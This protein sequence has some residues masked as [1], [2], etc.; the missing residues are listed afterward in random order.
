VRLP[1]AFINPTSCESDRR[2]TTPVLGRSAY[3]EGVVDPL[4]IERATSL[5]ID[6]RME[7]IGA[8]WDSIDHEQRPPSR[9]TA[10]LIAERLDDADANPLVGRTWDEIKRDWD[11]EGR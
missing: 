10:A 2:V 3:H 8:V 5:S 11:A 1:L 9:A 7:L 4:L 6:E